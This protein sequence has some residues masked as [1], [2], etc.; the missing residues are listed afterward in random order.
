LSC[1]SSPREQV[2]VFTSKVG[3]THSVGDAV[4]VRYDPND[5]HRARLD[6]LW[7]RVWGV[8]VAVAL[9]LGALG[10]T[11]AGGRLFVRAAAGSPPGR[12]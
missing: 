6:S 12:D 11:F 1:A 3:G 5:P 10:G 9:L 7:D 4:K 2:V 8:I